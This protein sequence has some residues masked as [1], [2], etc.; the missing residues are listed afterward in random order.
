MRPVALCLF[1]LVAISAALCQAQVTPVI[2]KQRIIQDVLDAQGNVVSHSETL[3][4]YLRNSAGSTITQTYSSLGGKPAIRWGQ[5]EDYSRHKI[6][7][8]DYERHQAMEQLDL[9]AGPHPEY[10]A[11]ASSALGEETVNG[12]PC[13]IH[14]IFVIAD[15]KKQLIGRA[16]DS[17][18][19]GLHIKEDAIVEPP[20]GPRTH[21]IV[22][23]YDIQVVEPDPKEFALEKFAFLEK[24]PAACDKPGAPASLE[25]LK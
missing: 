8:L 25:S 11:N 21:R 19:Y 9:P 20:G 7:T 10:L 15:R 5:L 6:Y 16:Y 13:L 4:R 18:E 1:V 22:E 23:L 24:R 14:S 3:G 2:A 17:A 12:I